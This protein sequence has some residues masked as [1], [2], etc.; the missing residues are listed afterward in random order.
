MEDVHKLQGGSLHMR[1]NLSIIAGLTEA[2]LALK[3]SCSF[4]KVATQIYCQMDCVCV[5]VEMDR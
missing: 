5:C 3:P 2:Y 1:H 4:C